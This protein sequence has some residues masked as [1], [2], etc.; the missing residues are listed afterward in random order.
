MRVE[1]MSRARFE[2]TNTAVDNRQT[3]HPEKLLTTG[4]LATLTGLSQSYFEK[5]RIYGYGP[6]FVRLR[7]ESRS[8][9]IRYRPEDVR[10]WLDNR[11]CSPEGAGDE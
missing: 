6:N 9:A 1:T 3:A 11:E 2:G 4:Q 5:G 8:G 7:P 10:R